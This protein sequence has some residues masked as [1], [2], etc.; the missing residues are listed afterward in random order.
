MEET[1]VKSNVEKLEL[2]S[3]EY[4]FNLPL[5]ISTF[6]VEAEYKKFIN[7]CEALVRRS[8]EY[9]LWR[10]YLVDVIGVNTCFITQERM[11]EVTI[12]IHHHI[13]SLYTLVSTLVNKCIEENEEF[14]SFDIC[15][16]A[17]ELHFTNRVG[18]VAL[19]KSMHEKF[20]NNK[21]DIPIG[22]VRGNYQYFL[23]N[24]TRYMDEVDLDIIQERLTMN[25]TNVSWT[26][27]NYP[28]AQQ[29]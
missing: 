1:T 3:D 18:Y 29:G 12:D 22:L 13:P 9:K 20:H 11:E 26:R 16:K 5:R 21:L 14:C 23:D 28:V 24:Y 8:R 4:P 7:N 2:Y 19:L 15:Q 10:Q 17:I 27:E 25:E 6:E